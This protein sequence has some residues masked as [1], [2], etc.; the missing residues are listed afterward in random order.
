MIFES[1]DARP[2]VKIDPTKDPLLTGSKEAMENPLEI[3]GGKG[4]QVMQVQQGGKTETI[5][6]EESGEDSL[7]T[8][9]NELTVRVIKTKVRKEW[10]GQFRYWKERKAEKH[11]HYLACA[12]LRQGV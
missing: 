7:E 6:C 4:T 2:K 9:T 1:S 3:I 8:C 12:A 10:E 5:T 11:V